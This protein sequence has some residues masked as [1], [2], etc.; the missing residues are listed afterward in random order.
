MKDIKK[1]IINKILICVTAFYF[2]SGLICCNKIVSVPEPINTIT[3]TETFSTEANAT[4]AVANIYSDMSYE[5][6]SARYGNGRTT[7]YAGMSADELSNFGSLSTYE[8]NTIL[9][10][11][12]TIGGYFWSPA[13]KDI[14]YAN[15]VIE[16]VQASLSLPVSVKN[17]LAGEAKFL[18]GF[19]YFY[20]VNLFG[21]VPLV[22]STP[23]AANSL[24]ARSPSSL[25]Y[26]QIITDL[27]DAQSLLPGD[28]SVSGGEKTRAN[29]F[30]A[31]AM[32]ARVFLYEQQWDSAALQATSLINS[33][34][35]S[36]DNPGDVFL[37]NSNEAILQL[38]T[39]DNTP[40][41]TQEGNQFV[42]RTPQST[43]NYYLT[44]QLLGAFELGDQRRLAWIDSSTAG[45]VVYYYPGKYKSRQ[46]TSGNVTEYYML[47]RFAE[48]YL[49]RAEARAQ[50]T[51]NDLIGALNDLNTIRNR[52]GLDSLPN[53]LTQSQALTAIEQERRIELFCEWGHR[54][55]DLKRWGT[56][57]QTLDTIPYKAG[58]INSSQLLYPI[59][60]SEIQTDP[61]L[62]Q[63]PGY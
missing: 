17:Q 33:G 41:A 13:Y 57:I 10:R 3:T 19:I 18:R 37:M 47:L 26:K 63:N 56:A 12:G 35:F 22:T 39:I 1:N 32:L 25:V 42:A 48:Q 2:M 36:L 45:G 6:N 59:P 46:A 31:T 16:G 53:F 49:I 5:N 20:L 14:Y 43:P 30:A 61:N 27:E 24:L 23:F 9:S 60:L 55:F 54:W 7:I 21:D 15:S 62:K 8:T 44:T 29:K 38:Q 51:P 40:F 52:A 58:N 11:D 34:N 4:S 50:Q 28:Y